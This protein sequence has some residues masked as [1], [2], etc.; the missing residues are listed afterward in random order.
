MDRLLLLGPPASGKGTQA[1]LLGERYNLPVASTGQMLLEEERRGT[2]IG[3]LSAE[4]RRT[5]DFLPDQTI[6]E[7]VIHWIAR[8]GTRFL[9]DGFP[10]TLVQARAFHRFLSSA[11]LAL[12]AAIVLDVPED[13]RRRRT[14]RRVTCCRCA[15]GF[16][17]DLGDCPNCGGEGVRRADDADHVFD[18]RVA[19]FEAHC[20][21]VIAYYREGNL[22]LEIDGAAGPGKVSDRL[23]RALQSFVARGRCQPR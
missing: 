13:E 21:P 4:L 22:L 2:D 16:D 18:R 1:A 12:D 15:V 19:L 3:R 9:F 17:R 8:H 10:R 6:L 20:R 23:D 5:G 7:M 14:V 11:G